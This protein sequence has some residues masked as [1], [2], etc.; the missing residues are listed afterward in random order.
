MPKKEPI[1]VVHRK[2]GKHKAIGLAWKEERII[3]LDTR[4]KGFDFLSVAIHEILHVQNP[5]WS[6]I[7]VEGHAKEMAEILWLQGFRKVDE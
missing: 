1:K 2:L 4:L 6:E 5:K 3:E 7:K